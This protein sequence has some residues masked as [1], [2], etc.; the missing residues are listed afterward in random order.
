MESIKN[1][2]YNMYDLKEKNETRG[3]Q[4]SV[5]A[6]CDHLLGKL[7]YIREYHPTWGIMRPLKF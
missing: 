1:K 4:S 6:C 2:E 3:R 7:P 5:R